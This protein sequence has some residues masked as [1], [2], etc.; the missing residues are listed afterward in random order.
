[1]NEWEARI[2]QPVEWLE[3]RLKVIRAD[4]AIAQSRINVAHRDIRGFDI[5]EPLI[6]AAIAKLKD[7]TP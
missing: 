6:E 7:G 5:E 3:S 1:M 4:R 2:A